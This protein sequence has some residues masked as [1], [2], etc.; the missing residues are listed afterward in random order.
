MQR[1]LDIYEDIAIASQKAT[2][3]SLRQA[4]AERYRSLLGIRPEKRHACR[5]ALSNLEG[6]QTVR[7]VVESLQED[8]ANGAFLLVSD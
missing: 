3:G 5:I 7:D 1:R 8:Q 4:L 6:G 2:S